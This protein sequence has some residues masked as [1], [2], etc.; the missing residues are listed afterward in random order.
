MAADLRRPVRRALCLAVL[1][2]VALWWPPLTGQAPPPR[3][4]PAMIHATDL[5]RPYADPDDHWDLAS[6]YA[7]AQSG[8]I[9]L[10]GIVVD[11]PPQRPTPVNPDLIA[12]AQMNHIA[13]LSV[14]VAT[15]TPVKMKTRTDTEP[16]ATLSDMAGVR[17]ILDILRT[18]RVPV[19]INVVGSG[20][21]VAVA[22]KREPALFAKKCRAIYLNAGT[23]TRTKGL[24][25]RKEYNVRLDEAGYAAIF[26]LPCPV[27]W[28]PC[29]EDNTKVENEYPVK[30]YG[31][32]YK[33]RHQDVL[34]VLAPRVQ[35][36]FGY[37]YRKTPGPYWLTALA[38]PVDPA[39]IQ[40][41]NPTFRNMWCT[42]G[43]LHA[44]GKTV[45]AD[46]RIVPL[47]DARSAVYSFDPIRVTADDSGDTEWHDDAASKTRFILHVRDIDH[48]QTAMT[49]ALRTLI[50]T[51]K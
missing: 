3:S 17:M 11:Y 13:G 9:D 25:T 18:S 1:L 21:D 36:F 43:F 24:I 10:R 38:E 14:P 28:L 19:I 5:F 40:E 50:Q 39:L 35:S 32:Y 26:D 41:L 20:R 33:F 12:I 51:L 7:L 34:P 47:K 29:F 44:A 46:G 30:A 45:M 22:G 49:S 4:A 16:E 8:D 15:G 23:G 6:V 31:S 48:Y 2:L 42:A 37:M 27:Y